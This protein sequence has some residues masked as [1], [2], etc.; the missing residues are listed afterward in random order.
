MT[1]V[2]VQG[3]PFRSLSMKR[4]LASV[5]MLALGLGFAAPAVAGCNSGNSPNT[6]LLVGDVA[7]QATASGSFA[8][9]IG[10]H[11]VASGLRSTAVGDN[12]LAKGTNSTALG[13]EAGVGAIVEGFTN[14]GAN[15]FDQAGFYSTA[16]G[17][18]ASFSIAPRA[19]G[20]WSIAIGGGDHFD[21]PGPLADG[22]FS[23]AI[24]NKSVATGTGYAVA[25]GFNAKANVGLAPTALGT[26][27]T[28]RGE[29]AA[30][31]GRFAG[32][33]A[34][35][36]T[37]LGSISNAVGVGSTAVGILSR[38]TR[39]NAVA[40]GTG[41]LNN[42]SG[43]NI[44]GALNSNATAVGYQSRATGGNSSALGVRSAAFGLNSIAIGAFA[45]ASHSGSVALGRSSVT[46]AANTVSV[47]SATLKR[48]VM[49]VANAVAPNDAV[50]LAQVQAMLSAA[51]AAQS[52][53]SWDEPDSS[54]AALLNAFEEQQKQIERQQ[55]LIEK[56]QSTVARLE[57]R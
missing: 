39:A 50:N 46:S 43:G 38:A 45:L 28:A 25:L 54:A 15:S 17:A 49:N 33:T 16:I 34:Q 53:T 41:F 56:L 35:N 3:A 32:A 9:G 27:S 21:R 22:I 29:N 24:G 23:V 57:R 14:I 31:F 10:D 36:A 6:N 12:A 55:K 4:L 13:A 1:T 42:G 48:R 19:V 30:A 2:C 7:C 47:G 37:A 44:A 5:G 40:L 52:T 26:D 8:V 18:G 51:P 20:A 11:T